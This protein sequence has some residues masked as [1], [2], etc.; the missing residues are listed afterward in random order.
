MHEDGNTMECVSF[1]D[2]GQVGVE[3]LRGE[4]GEAFWQW[5]AIGVPVSR[6]FMVVCEVAR[7]HTEGHLSL[8]DERSEGT[9]PTKYRG[10][11]AHHRLDS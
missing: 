7:L 6:L 4:R 1:N 3:S 8:H 10:T 5:D 11:G 9:P 2:A